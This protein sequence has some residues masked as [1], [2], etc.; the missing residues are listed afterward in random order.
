MKSDLFSRVD[1]AAFGTAE[2]IDRRLQV[3]AEELS[4]LGK[5]RSSVLREVADL[6]G[7]VS[8]IEARILDLMVEGFELRKSVD[9]LIYRLDQKLD[10]ILARLNDDTKGKRDE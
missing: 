10:L 3:M 6:R 2:R 8:Y 9:E 4:R 1:E 5:D 7:G